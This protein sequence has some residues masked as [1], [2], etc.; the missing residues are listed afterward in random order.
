MGR[1]AHQAMM[2]AIDRLVGERIGAYMAVQGDKHNRAQKHGAKHLSPATAANDCGHSHHVKQKYTV[3]QLTDVR[4]S[5]GLRYSLDTPTLWAALLI[6]TP[7]A[8]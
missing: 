2:S 6:R 3:Q 8:A 4:G 7:E 1:N 5:V